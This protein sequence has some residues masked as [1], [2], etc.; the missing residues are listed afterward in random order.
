MFDLSSLRLGDAYRS[1]RK[2]WANPDDTAAV[3][4]IIGAL[5]AGCGES[6][7]ARF[8][9]SE[10]GPRILSEKRD[11]LATLQDRDALMAMPEGSLGRTY[12]EFTA[13]EAISADGLVEASEQGRIEREGLDEDRRRYFDRLRDCHDLQ[14]VVTGWGRD[15]RG[16]GALLSFGTAQS[17]H[18]G[19]AFIVA[20]AY[21]DGDGEERRV[22]REAWQ[23][24][25]KAQ[26]LDAADWEA[27]LPRPLD[28][29]R[30]ELGVEP[31]PAYEPL[32]SQAAT[33]AAPERSA[34]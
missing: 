32:W 14:H 18:H 28:E 4:E 12:A 25:R 1:W 6:S 21:L 31:P 29:V 8:R 13:R 22:I 15:L 10:H 33:E 20:M 30:A 3:F 7:F 23:R 34:A 5:D 9:K 19:V 11:L 16:E 17:W 26:W 2:L 27:L 24:G